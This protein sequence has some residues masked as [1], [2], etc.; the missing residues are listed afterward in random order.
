MKQQKA[1]VRSGD[2][3]FMRIMQYDSNQSEQ[4]CLLLSLSTG[5]KTEHSGGKTCLETGHFSTENHGVIIKMVNSSV[6]QG[7][8]QLC[9]SFATF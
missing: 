6:K 2:H 1:T 9:N 8:K 3:E 4:I 7:H 5:C